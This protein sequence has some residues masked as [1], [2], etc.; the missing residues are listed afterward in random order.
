MGEQDFIATED[1]VALALLDIYYGIELGCAPA[2]LRR[3]GWTVVPARAEGDPMRLLFGRRLLA[4]LVSPQH[5]AGRGGEVG[6]VAVVV[7][8]LR[9]LVGDFLREHSARWLFT[10]RGMAA[11]DALVRGD[12]ASDATTGTKTRLSYALSTAFRPYVGQWLEWIEPLDEAREM[13]PAALGLLARYS[14]GVYVVRERGAILGYAGLQAHSPHVW[15]ISTHTQ[16]DVE[17]RDT[18][19]SAMLSRATRAVLSEGRLPLFTYAGDDQAGARVADLLGY[20]RYGQV[21]TL[22]DVS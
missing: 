11:L 22:A 15:T 5:H 7:P 4:Q 6:G 14:G 20:R 8:E 18:L 9:S 21:I 1:Q 19:A 12:R 2:D 13:D 16:A 3:P 17:Q 10:P